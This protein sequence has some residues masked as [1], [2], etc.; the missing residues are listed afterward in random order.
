MDSVVPH[1]HV[2]KFETRLPCPICI[3]VQ[4]EKVA[5]ARPGKRLVLDHCSR[6][7]G[8]W[9]EKGEPQH[10]TL[11][12]PAE[13]WK[14]I[15]PRSHIIRPP[16]HGCGSPMDR[17][18]L[19]CAV[20]KRANEIAC[21]A[22]DIKTER[23]RAEGLTLDVCGRCKGVWFEHAEL[24]SVWTLKLNEMARRKP[25]AMLAGAAEGGS[26]ITDALMY[27]PD[28]VV[29][30]A[31]AIGETVSAVGRL[32]SSGGVEAASGVLGALGDAASSVFEAIAEI[33]GGLSS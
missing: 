3:G 28:L 11:H 9:F 15:P 24:R 4:M 16:C 27:S 33:L 32:A 30:G 31:H 10:L 12:A 25:P 13:L 21:P 7:G 1:G 14:Y 2:P 17:D 18:C 19:E 26:L 22:C 20:C 23:V 5:L 6:C 29:Y 8:V